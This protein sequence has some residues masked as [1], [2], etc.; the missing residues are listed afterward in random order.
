MNKEKNMEKYFLLILLTP[1]ILS[2][3]DPVSW[4]A[5][6]ALGAVVREGVDITKVYIYGPQEQHK[7]LLKKHL[8]SDNFNSAIVCGCNENFTNEC[9]DLAKHFEALERYYAR[10]HELSCVV[11]QIELLEEGDYDTQDLKEFRQKLRS[12]NT[13]TYSYFRSL[14]AEEKQRL[15]VLQRRLVITYAKPENYKKELANLHMAFC[16]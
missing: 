9:T 1:C 6:P 2:G 15:L 7:R 13:N 14:S 8:D 11:D 16:K 3:V 4:I 10:S 12:E 5:A